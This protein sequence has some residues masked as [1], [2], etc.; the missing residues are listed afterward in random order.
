MQ[1]T[2]SNNAIKLGHV[3]VG[4]YNK[5]DQDLIEKMDHSSLV[6]FSYEGLSSTIL[7]SKD[8]SL[9]IEF[10]P[11]NTWE[12]YK[13]NEKDQSS[14]HLPDDLMAKG[15]LKFDY[16]YERIVSLEKPSK[17]IKVRA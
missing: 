1:I 9:C 11:N 7:V 12:M 14:E 17:Q 16:L 10:K 15:K 5:Y 6:Q 3:V 8:K 2:M 13:Y 4:Y